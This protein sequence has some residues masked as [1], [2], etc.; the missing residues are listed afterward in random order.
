[1]K[2]NPLVSIIIPSYNQGRYLEETIDSILDQDYRPLEI[3][4]LDGQSTDTTL[5]ILKSYKD[6]PE[7]KW[8]SEPDGGVT[9]AV[10][11]GLERACGEIFAIQSS[12][13]VYLPGA[14]SAAVEFLVKH[15]DVALVYGDVE[16]MNEHSQI[17]GRDILGPFDFKHY[18][19][20]FSYIP[21]PAAF[22]RADTAR[23]IGGWRK[24]VGYTADADYWLR[25][26][27]TRT[28]MKL[29]RMLGR[30]RY[31]PEQ[32]DRQS[33]DIARDWEKT[34]LDLLAS[35]SFDKSAQRYARMGI[36]LAKY[37][38]APKGDWSKRTYY[39]YRALF[40]NPRAVASCQF[41]KR[42]LLPGR[43]P[44]WRI[45]SRVKRSLGFKQRTS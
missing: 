41:P 20:R 10:N 44:L 43:E 8:W 7:L 24:E 11:K 18:V 39:L 28:V 33:A 22:F 30:Y 21:Q 29:D 2:V 25:I 23:V 12:D 3:L 34:I 14:I 37:R 26:A 5:S 42:E 32:R 38:Y 6:V 27:A 31:H 17:T 16:L 1:M 35:H 13:D 15:G 45:L 4:V 19:G 36:Y 40:E 9:D